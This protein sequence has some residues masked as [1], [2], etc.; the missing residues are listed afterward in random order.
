MPDQPLF[1]PLPPPQPEL[2]PRVGFAVRIGF[3]LII[4]AILY[5]F[6][7]PLLFGAFGVVTAA[8]IGLFLVALLANGLTLR[9]F[10]RGSLADIG[11]GTAGASGRNFLIGLAA[12]SGSA[13]LLMAIPLCVGAAHFELRQNSGFAWGGLAFYLAALL[14]GAVGE[15]TLFRGY[16]F[17]LAIERFGPYATVLPVAVLFGYGHAANPH[18]NPLAIFNTTL[19]GVLLGYA[20]LRSRDLWLPIGLHYGWN[21]A[22]PLFGA[23]LSGLT[24]E[25]TRYLYKWDL[26]S[27]WSGGDYG[28]EGGLL[29]TL[30]VLILFP[31]LRVAP[32]AP[33]RSVLA[34][35]L[36]SSSEVWG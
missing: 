1:S 8:T 7:P 34:P 28:P 27:L 31:V 4:G 36:N 22:L 24:I 10:D 5:F 19:W 23:T 18:A 11:L 30:I 17:Q 20:F 16:A 33:Q 13:V 15:E 2:D 26:G 21:V 25:V 32:I 6:L 29:T 9:V 14:F 3:Y 35:S 12:G